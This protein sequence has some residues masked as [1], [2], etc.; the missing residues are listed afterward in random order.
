MTQPSEKPPEFVSEA[1]FLER[2]RESDE[3]LEY[4]DGAIYAMAGEK[5][6][7]NRIAGNLY[8]R[9]L[10]RA[11]EHGCRVYMEGVQLR[12]PK[13]SKYFL[14]DVMLACAPEG[15]DEYIEENPCVLVEVVSPTSVIRDYNEK[16][17]EYFNIPSLQQYLLVSSDKKQVEVYTRETSGWHYEVY[18][19]QGEFEVACV[20]L[21][22]TLE[23]IYAAVKL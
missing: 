18:L 11:D 4:S 15:E 2:S 7:N 1:E 20:G 17:L 9:L 12:L 21:T 3:R 19:E 10:A 14:P 8:S 22:V 16:K 13:G 23:Q 6:K 5:K